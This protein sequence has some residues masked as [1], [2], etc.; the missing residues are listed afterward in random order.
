MSAGRVQSVDG[1][2]CAGEAMS[3]LGVFLPCLQGWRSHV[4]CAAVFLGLGAVRYRNNEKEER[5]AG[6]ACAGRYRAC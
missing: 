3:W 1:G 5:G 4:Q 6:D 2:L